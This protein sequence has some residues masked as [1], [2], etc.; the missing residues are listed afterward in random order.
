MACILFGFSF[1]SHASGEDLSVNA[2]SSKN[3]FTV[4]LV[5]NPTTG[6]Q[7]EVTEYDKNLLILSESHYERPQT[8]LIGAGGEMLFTFTLKKGKIY[9]ANTHMKFKYSRS[10]EPGSSTVKNITVNFVKDTN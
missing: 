2:D 8:N 3:S 4:K 7:W 1:F 9:P 6:F 10:W 5:A